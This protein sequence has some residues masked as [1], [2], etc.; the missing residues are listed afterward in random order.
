TTADLGFALLM[1]TARRLTEASR[2]IYEDKWGDWSP[3]MLAGTDIYNKTIGI[4]G[5]GRIGQA[6]ARRAKGFN[7]DIIYHNRRRNERAEKELGA[8]YVSFAEL[9]ERADYVVSVV[10]LTE[11]TENL[12]DAN[13]FSKMKRS[14]IFVNISRGGVVDEDAL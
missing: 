11:E 7:M 14:G 10:P 1:A 2:Y 9:L 12:F 8:T 6:I 3:F 5:M 13:A 4:V